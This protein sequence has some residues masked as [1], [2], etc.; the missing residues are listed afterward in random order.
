MP[1]PKPNLSTPAAR[2]LYART[3]HE[4]GMKSL[5]TAAGLSSAAVQYIESNPSSDPG[6]GTLLRLARQLDVHPAWLAYG[7]GPMEPFPP[8][9]AV[10]EVPSPPRKKPSPK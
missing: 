2:L 8:E 10:D 9:L 1:T 3:L 4:F 6:V 5:S 7:T